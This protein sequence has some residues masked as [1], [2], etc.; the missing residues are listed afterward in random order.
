MRGLFWVEIFH[1]K[2]L[3]WNLHLGNLF[4]WKGVG[5]IFLVVSY[6][7]SCAELHPEKKSLPRFGRTITYLEEIQVYVRSTLPKGDIHH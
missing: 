3:S 4:Q 6:K 1:K 7:K 2:H 5:Y